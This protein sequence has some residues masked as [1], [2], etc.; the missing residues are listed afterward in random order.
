MCLRLA[1]RSEAD[2]HIPRPNANQLPDKA[3][4]EHG[5]IMMMM[6]TMI[7]MTSVVVTLRAVSV[8]SRYDSIPAAVVVSIS[9]SVMVVMVI[10]LVLVVI[11][12]ILKN[13][14]SLA[15]IDWS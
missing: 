10:V 8:S 12:V 7:M 6:M 15:C 5:P 1:L 3:S 2:T 13:L 11:M 9:I 14:M 4:E